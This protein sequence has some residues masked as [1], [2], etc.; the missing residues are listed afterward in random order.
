MSCLAP[1]LGSLAG[2]RQ[3]WVQAAPGTGRAG[4]S[5]TAGLFFGAAQ[6]RR[7]AWWEPC[8]GRGTVP[9]PG[10]VNVTET[11]QEPGC[12][13]GVRGTAVAGPPVRGLCLFGWWGKGV[14]VQLPWGWLWGT[15][16]QGSRSVHVGGHLGFEQD[17]RDIRAAPAPSL[18]QRAEEPCRAACP[19]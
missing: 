2:C 15:L 8:T 11:E 13:P 5:A 4:L 3:G 18:Q 19:L 1:G 9:G 16:K 17:R 12:A 14:A 6:S 7:P 10:D